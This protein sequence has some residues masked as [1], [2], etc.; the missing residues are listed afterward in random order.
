MAPAGALRAIGLVAIAKRRI[1]MPDGSVETFDVGGAQIEFMGDVVCATIIF[2]PDDC[3]P[4]LGVTAWQSV[5][6]ELDL[7]N[8]RLKRSPTVRL[9]AIQTVQ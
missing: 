4:I 2:G 5:G 6:I 1:E 7:R 9:K 3:E 8:Q